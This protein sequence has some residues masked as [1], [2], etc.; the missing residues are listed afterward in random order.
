V[1]LNVRQAMH[2]LCVIFWVFCDEPPGGKGDSA[3]QREH[4]AK[5]LFFVLFAQQEPSGTG[6]IPPGAKLL[7]SGR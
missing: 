2:E 4:C 3:R 6:F 5:I 1:A 7:I